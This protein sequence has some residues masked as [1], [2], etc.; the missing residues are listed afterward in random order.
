MKAR[1]Y[2]GPRDVQV[3]DMPDSQSQQAARWRSSLTAVRCRGDREW[4]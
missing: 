2:N 1:I 3:K 4:G